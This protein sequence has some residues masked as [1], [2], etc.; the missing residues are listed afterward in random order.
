MKKNLLLLMIM[1][2][3]ASASV[4]Q[5]VY[6]TGYYTYTKNGI[7]QKAAALY[8]NGTTI[9]NWQSIYNADLEGKEVVVATNGKVYWVYNNTTDDKAFVSNYTDSISIIYNEAN[10]RINA[11]CEGDGYIYSV[12]QKKVNGVWKA[13]VWRDDQFFAFLGDGGYDFYATSACFKDGHL[14]TTVEYS[15]GYGSGS[16]WK[17]L[18]QLY[19]L[20]SGVTPRDVFVYDEDVYTTGFVQDF[21]TDAYVSKVWKNDEELYT[22]SPNATMLV[23]YAHSIYIDAG[24]IYVSGFDEEGHG[25]VW[26]N[27]VGLYT[28]GQSLNAVSANSSGVYSAGYVFDTIVHKWVG[29]IWKDGFDPYTPVACERI[30]GMFVTEPECTNSAARPLPFYESFENGET[31]WPCWIKLD[32]DNSNNGQVSYWERSGTRLHSVPNGGNHCVRHTLNWDSNQEGWLISP[33]LALPSSNPSTL[34]FKTAESYYSDYTYEGVWIST[35]GTNPSNFTQVWT[36]SN[37]TGSWKTVTVDLSAYQG[38]NVYIGFKY[39]GI[40]GHDWYIDEV[41]VEEEDPNTATITVLADPEEGGTVTGGGVYPITGTAAYALTATPNPGWSFVNWTKDGTVVGTDPIYEILPTADATYVAHFSQSY[42]IYIG[43]ESTSTSSYLPSYTYY[44]Y[45]LTQQIYTPAEIG[46]AGAINSIAFYNGGEVKTRFYDLYLVHTSNFIFANGNSWITVAESDRVFSGSVTMIA[47]DWTWIIFDTPF[48]YNGTSN[49]ALVVN[50]KTGDWSSE[51]ACRVFNTDFNQAIR[52]YTDNAAYNPMAPSSYSGTVM[53]VKN[54]IKMNGN[55]TPMLNITATVTGNGGYVEGGGSFNNGAHCT[56]IAYPDQGYDL[57]NWTKNGVVVSTDQIYTF[58]VT[59]SAEYVAHFEPLNGVYIGGS[60]LTNVTYL[61]TISTQLYALTNQIYTADELGGAA[62]F[63]G[64]AFY[65]NGPG[66][67][68][69]VDLYLQPTTRQAFTNPRIWVSATEDNRV[70]SG[71]MILLSEGWSWITFD[72]PFEYD[73]TSNLALIVDDN[74]GSIRPT[75]LSCFSFTTETNQ[76]NVIYSSPVEFNQNYSN[77]NFNPYEPI[78]SDYEGV[79]VNK[80]NVIQLRRGAHEETE[81]YIGDESTST[82]SYLPSYSLYNYSLTQQIYTADEISQAGT[83]N[84]IAFYNDGDQRTRDFDFYLVHTDKASVE[85]NSDWIPVVESDR[86][87][88]GTV[89]MVAGDWTRITFD[90]PFQYDGT[91]NLALI[92]CDKTGSC[93]GGMACR[94]FYAD[95]DGYQTIRTYTDYT[96]YNPMAPSSYTGTRMAEKNQIKLGIGS[97]QLVP[98]TITATA[99]PA[100]GGTVTGGGTYNQ[101]DEVT[102]MATPNEGYAFENWTKNGNVV[103][104]TRSYTF[105]VTESAEYV[106]NFSESED[107]ELTVHDGTTTNSY[108]PVYGFYVDCYQRS[109]FV[110][111]AEELTDMVNGEISKMTFYLSNPASGAWNGVFQVYMTEVDYTAISTFIDPSTATTVFTGVLDGTGTEM[112]VSFDNNYTYNGGNLLIGFD[113]I[114]TGSYYPAYFFGETVPSASVQG[115]NCFSLSAV[116]PAQQNFLPKTTFTY[117][118]GGVPSYTITATANPTES[119]TVTGGGTYNSGETCILT[120]TANTDY[121]FVNWTKDDNEVSTNATYSFEVTED[122]EYV[123][124]FSLGVYIGDGNTTT[125]DA[126]LPS[127]SM[128]NY[129]LTEQIYTADEL[130]SGGTISSLAFYN[131]SSEK[132]RSYNVYMVHTAKAAFENM[133]DWIAVTPSDRVFSGSVTLI[134]D[135]WTWVNFDTPFPYDGTSNIAVVVEDQTGDIGNGKNEM[136]CLVFDAEGNQAIRIYGDEAAFDPTAPAYNGVL[137]GVKNQI[138]IEFTNEPIITYSI[139]ATADPTEGGTVA[140]AGTYQ[141]G[142]LCTLTATANTGYTFANWTKDGDVVSTSATYTFTVTE[143]ADLVAHFTASEPGGDITQTTNFTTG[144]NWYST[145]VEQN[146]IDGLAQLEGSLGANGIQIKSQGQYLNYYEG[147]GWMGT[148]SGIGNESSY[149]IKANAPCV[150]NMTGA[151]TTSASHPITIGP[152]WNWIGYPVSTAMSIGEAMSGITPSNGDQLKGLNGYAS[153]YEGMGWMGTLSTIT[154]GMGLL[155]K[156]TGSGS[157]TLVYPTSSKGE[158]LAEN[159]TP[160]NNH[161][162]PDLHAY[163]DNMTVTAIIELD[164]EELNSENYELAAFANGECRGSVRLMYVEPLNRYMAF[165]TIAGEDV[166]TLSFSLYDAATGEEIHGA[167]EM[168]N[169]SDNAIVGSANE[170]Y[171]IRFRSLTGMDEFGSRINV[172]PNPIARG[173]MLNITVPTEDLGKMQIEIINALGQVVEICHGASLQTVTAPQVAGV[174]TLRIT[175]EGKGTYYRKLVVR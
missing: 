123:A 32:V 4:A 98:C 21:D 134:A 22:L 109:Q 141:S 91:S 80:K 101:S 143:D 119:G 52:A 145:Y 1:L 50:D 157:Q 41:S 77:T 43:D 10:A 39:T 51:M 152:G 69:N 161:W 11:I 18:E 47:G 88:S 85:N 16:V 115:Q 167:Q 154:P 3:M 159:V 164:N 65:N 90:T 172:F 66:Q 15:A 29:K 113:E 62:T 112:E 76:S 158:A 168:L 104:N 86:V 31:D 166:T 105:T 136:A 13:A 147:M 151:E 120:A 8:K 87:F 103:S 23:S 58:I 138:Q 140:G 56:L 153:Y 2:A 54:Q 131:S 42:E 149:K 102:L 175:V 24:D 127:S 49:L 97:G 74:T 165:L 26:K 125:T 60:G 33:K 71:N 55:F 155:Y 28:A 89:T 148:L 94:V 59:E 170:P 106:A 160:E 171:V 27:G 14:Y 38:Q 139:T 96:A 20:G 133:N 163:P 121:I 79:L 73:G 78:Q 35:T 142:Q 111:P 64:I 12:G 36:Q 17:D 37:P 53:N 137:M 45:S 108:V 150:I 9:S 114:E 75:N 19:Q 144:W 40:E 95:A 124:N 135:G 130:G 132:T 63:T 44:N 72:T 81:I 126:N 92:A 57:A 7:T 110:M 169:F 68:R 128:Y 82:S 5:D 34:T 61:P 174:Y 84:S 48:Q 117:T 46:Q 30:N 173:E 83:V 118:L 156:S 122:A 67:M 25:K 107:N 70:F 146:D 93:S 99:N 100:E 116:T 129:S 6:S 162:V